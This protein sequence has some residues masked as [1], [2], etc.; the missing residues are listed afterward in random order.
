MHEDFTIEAFRCLEAYLQTLRRA[1]MDRAAQIARTAHDDPTA[2]VYVVKPVHVS[3][4]WEE[5]KAARVGAT[6]RRGPTASGE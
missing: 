3:R 5:L 1:V 4:A 2:D 6:E